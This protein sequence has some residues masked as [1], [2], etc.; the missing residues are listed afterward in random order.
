[1]L[2]WRLKVANK[3]LRFAKESCNNA[4]KFPRSIG[5][6]YGLL[7]LSDAAWGVREDGSSQGGYMILAVPPRMFE[8]QNAEYAVL[9]WKS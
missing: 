2:I 5:V 6:N 8:D 9:D 4:L 3:T 7:S 1:M